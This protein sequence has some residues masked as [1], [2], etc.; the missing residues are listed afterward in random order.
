MD[1]LK[2]QFARIQEQLNGL[3]ASQ[4]MLTAAL[5]AIMVM[6]LVWWGKYAGDPEMEAVLPQNLSQ[7]DIGPITAQLRADGIPYRTSG[8]QILVPAERRL[9]A[10]GALG[11]AKV[12]PHSTSSGF[13]EMI[14][15]VSPFASPS[16]TAE[17]LKRAREQALAEVIRHFP[18]VN[19]A[20]VMVDPAPRR[21]IGSAASAPSATVNIITNGTTRSRQ[22]AQAAADLV[23]GANAGLTAG[24]VKVVVDGTPQRVGAEIDGSEG[25]FENRQR[26]E[27][28]YQQK[29]A[30]LLQ[31]MGQVLIAVNAHV[32]LARTTKNTTSYDKNSSLVLPRNESSQNAESSGGG[33]VGGEPGV[34]P[35]TVGG[36]GVAANGAA[37]VGG[38]GGVGGEATTTESNEQTTNETYAGRSETHEEKGPGETTVVSASVRVPRSY[39]VNVL[40]GPDPSAKEPD[41][42]KLNDFIQ[43]ELASVRAAVRSCTGIKSDEQLSV[44]AYYDLPLAV[45]GLVKPQ[46]ASAGGLPFGLGAYAKQLALGGLALVSLFLVSMMVRKAS[47]VA[48]V[49]AVA[50]VASASASPIAAGPALVDS[51][52]PVAGEASGGD[53]MMAGMELDEESVRTRQMIDQVSTLVQENPDAAATLVKR[54]LNRG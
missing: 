15:Q 25:Q 41:E 50:S 21:Q 42:K 11:F 38:A 31:N 46:L 39:F 51:A 5:V 34:G 44:D 22:L 26:I 29:I 14:R 7:E 16:Q 2:N 40:R 12:L 10:L 9:E 54:W 43:A 17:V 4:K 3:T 28:D 36:G 49:V 24:N 35:N 1:T 23:T 47:P 30:D 33:G 27:R 20:F 6:T 52:E 18:G 53:P 19:E 45:P 48:P 8:R 32:D 13:D 37:S